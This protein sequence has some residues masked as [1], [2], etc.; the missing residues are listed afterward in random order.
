MIEGEMEMIMTAM[1]RDVSD[2]RYVYMYVYC[3]YT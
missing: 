1:R 3:V 2:G